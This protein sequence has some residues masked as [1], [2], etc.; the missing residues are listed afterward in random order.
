[1]SAH[2]ART[3]QNCLGLNDDG[4][5]SAKTA[6]VLLDHTIAPL[7]AQQPIVADMPNEKPLIV[8]RFEELVAE[9]GLGEY[10]Q[11]SCVV[12]HATFEV[13][14]EDVR[15]GR[16]KHDQEMVIEV[17]GPLR[18]RLAVD[19]ALTGSYAP[20]A[21]SVVLA[22]FDTRDMP[23]DLQ[24]SVN[25]MQL[26]KE[27]QLGRRKAGDSCLRDYILLSNSYEP[28]GR[29]NACTLLTRPL[30]CEDPVTGARFGSVEAI[31]FDSVHL[32][33]NVL[34]KVEESDDP[35]M[36]A[37]CARLARLF[38][39]RQGTLGSLGL[40]DSVN[41]SA[42]SARHTPRKRFYLLPTIYP[43]TS[44]LTRVHIYL[45]MRALRE[46]RAHGI[47]NSSID[48]SMYEL[49]YASDKLVFPAPELEEVIEFINT[50]LLDV[51]P[52]FDP[53]RLSATITP[54][55]HPSWIDAWNARRALRRTAPHENQLFRCTITLL[56]YYALC[57]RPPQ[58]ATNTA[59]KRA[60]ARREA[61]RAA[62]AM[63]VYYS[64]GRFEGDGEADA[65]DSESELSFTSN[66][67]NRTSSPEE[68]KVPYMGESIEYEMA[69]ASTSML[70]LPL[71]VQSEQSTPS[72]SSPPTFHFSDTHPSVARFRTTAATT[73]TT[74][75]ADDDGEGDEDDSDA[76]AVDLGAQK[77]DEQQSMELANTI[78]G[79]IFRLDE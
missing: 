12:G 60:L 63:P 39:A 4:G 21:L 57:G 36:A 58:Y 55:A 38:G 59:N 17:A 18:T 79:G 15:R 14:E 53:L 9:Q 66:N 41:Q 8:G 46:S 33:N 74:S 56:I 64:V 32:L 19:C 27:A 67:G 26:S 78:D 73:T 71:C 44:L 29:A 25:G 6:T 28:R 77:S 22:G 54:F 72:K 49:P 10:I 47:P 43:Y 5:L 1:M 68:A 34:E 75:S 13:S 30:V 37:H 52:R 65:S 31:G 61:L 76:T 3:F 70:Q 35:Q 16:V 42:A 2:I 23:F 20:H 11:T 51:H 50:H 7:P 69:Q 45:T 24:L 48:R 62:K 40:F